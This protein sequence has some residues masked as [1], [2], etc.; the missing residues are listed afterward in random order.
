M[1]AFKHGG[2]KGQDKRHYRPFFQAPLLG[3]IPFSSSTARLCDTIG[4]F[5]W[6]RSSESTSAHRMT[7]PT[8]AVQGQGLMNVCPFYHFCPL[9][10]ERPTW[11]TQQWCERYQ[12]MRWLEVMPSR[13]KCSRQWIAYVSRPSEGEEVAWEVFLL[14]SFFPFLAP[15]FGPMREKQNASVN[16]VRTMCAVEAGMICPH[17]YCFF[18]G[19]SN[20][21]S[22]RTKWA[23]KHL[24][25]QKEGRVEERIRYAFKA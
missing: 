16:K 25:S 19:V 12:S 11:N 3:S 5:A 21:L 4:A 18:H 17:L 10:W 9:V 13:L 14:P 7:T 1:H 24:W 6:H 15:V 2:E 8:F 22:F 20:K 23:F